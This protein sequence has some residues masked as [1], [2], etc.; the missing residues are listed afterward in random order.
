MNQSISLA[1]RKPSELPK[2]WIEPTEPASTISALRLVAGESTWRSTGAKG[3][4]NL[5][6]KPS[7]NQVTRRVDGL[8]KI[9][10][11]NS[12]ARLSSQ[13]LQTSSPS[14]G[15][16]KL[17]L[18]SRSIED[19]V[20]PSDE[21]KFP[22]PFGLDTFS[23]LL[24]GC[25]PASEILCFAA[26]RLAIRS[27]PWLCILDGIIWGLDICWVSSLSGFHEAYARPRGFL[28]SLSLPFS[29]RL[30]S[31]IR[32]THFVALLSSDCRVSQ[33]SGASQ[34]GAT[35]LLYAHCAD[36]LATKQALLGLPPRSTLS[37][38]TYFTFHRLAMKMFLTSK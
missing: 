28:F 35:W 2:A 20:S 33:V 7:I 10:S 6:S 16:F 29:T 4:E 31:L 12:S 27:V 14:M 15:A 30:D 36:A 9:G 3:R 17:T 8:A 1:N 23:R 32:L 5:H 25:S 24:L 38:A 21:Q 19:Q 18:K 13:D 11:A 26:I 34:T 22:S 37:G